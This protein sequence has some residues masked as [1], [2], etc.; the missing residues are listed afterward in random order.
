MSIAARLA[1]CPAALRRTFALLVV[2]SI[3]ALL[4]FTLVLP[5]QSVQQSQQA[6]RRSTEK[7]LAKSRVVNQSQSELEKQ[8]QAVRASALWGKFYDPSVG[9]V[10]SALQGDVASCLS[11]AGASAQTLTPIAAS[12]YHSLTSIGVRVT[13]S[14]R[15]D[16][17]QRFFSAIAQNSRYLRIQKLTIS[18]PQLQSPDENPPLAV[19][20][21]VHG[22]ETTRPAA[23]AGVS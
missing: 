2:P 14:M 10:G 15:M 8:L 19:T 6:W 17:L 21:E 13:S 4:L 22:F 7:L 20:V 23:P 5:L 18:A 1:H 11:A 3:L 16:Q 12:E 9:N